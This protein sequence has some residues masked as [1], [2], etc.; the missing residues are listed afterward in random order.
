VE[1]VEYAE[2]LA[3]SEALITDLENLSKEVPDA[4]RHAGNFES[5]E[6]VK[7]VPLDPRTTPPSRSGLALSSTPNRKQCSLTFSVQM[8]KFLR[9][10][11]RTCLAYWGMSL[12]TR[13]I[14]ELEPDPW[15]SLCADS[16]KKSAEP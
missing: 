6:M 11:P 14:S 10:V 13:W 12:S 4:K 2:A 1:C 5:A 3:E 15:S 16:T 7:S 8:P 9:G